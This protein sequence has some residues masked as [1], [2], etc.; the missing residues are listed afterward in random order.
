ML[1]IEKDL[2]NSYINWIEKYLI[3]DEGSKQEKI[4]FLLQNILEY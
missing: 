3:K 2:F 1:S 4:R